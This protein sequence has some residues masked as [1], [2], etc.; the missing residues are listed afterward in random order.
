MP[1]DFSAVPSGVPI[2][3]GRID[4]LN[5]RAAQLGNSVAD[6]LQTLMATFNEAKMR[7]SAEADKFVAS[8]S[9]QSR[10]AAIQLTKQ[11]LAQ[12]VA[13]LRSDLIASSAAARADLLR[14]LQAVADEAAAIGAVLSSPGAM[15][16]RM[17]MGEARK[18]ELIAQL[19]GAGTMELEGMARMAIMI[20]DQVLAAAVLLVVDRQPRE[21]RA[22]PPSEFA[23]RVMG[24]DF[25]ALDVKLKAIALALRSALAANREFERGAPDPLTNISLALARGALKRPEGDA[26]PVAA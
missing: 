20:G 8:T 4:E 17:G 25:D 3:P 11:R 26:E 23:Q 19:N 18:S 12:Q 6:R 21:R 22:F 7:F 24:K 16:G 14:Q 5:A 13:D 2:S 1:I 10:A 9:G 15:L